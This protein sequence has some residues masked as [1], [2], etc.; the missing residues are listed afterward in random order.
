MSRKVFISFLGATNYGECEYLCE[1]KSY[2]R[3]RFIQ[4][5]TIRHLMSKE[6]WLPTDAAYI[7]MTVTSETNN[8][9]DFHFNNRDTGEPLT[10]LHS[11]LEKLSLP[12]P[13]HTI[14]ELPD[15]NNEQEIWQIFQ[16][17]FNECIQEG[18]ELYFDI[19][20]GYRYLPM[21]IVVLGN[22]AKFL[23]NITVKSITYGNYEISK[24][25]KKPG[26]IVDLLPL[27]ALQDWTYA[28]G[29]YIRSG[30]ASTLVKLGNDTVRPLMKMHKGQDK[31]TNNLYALVK[32]LDGLT[33]ELRTCRGSELIAAKTLK[34]LSEAC[35]EI[36]AATIPQLEPLISKIQESLTPFSLE[37][38]VKNGF[39][40]VDWCFNHGLYQ[41]AATLLE[42]SIITLLC[43]CA[44]LDLMN[45]TY[46]DLV[47]AA[48][49]CQ[50]HPE[51]PLKE[52]Y[53][54]Q[55]QIILNIQG[56][57][58]FE[59]LC[60]VYAPLSELRN[61]FNHAGMRVNHSK[62]DDIVIKLQ[63]YIATTKEI[64]QKSPSLC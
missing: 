22:Y 20:H 19:T 52:Q 45:R 56:T 34:R 6:E 1:G 43:K 21:L 53:K 40:A 26:L 7:L 15:G 32:S 38:D 59:E 54:E 49:Y 50:T 10:G 36:E 39:A 9:V 14:R 2:G 58:G 57:M 63:T 24:L 8:W 16:R 48:I 37:E 44:D 35:G 12:F 3:T 11:C 25:K 27:S 13:V 33:K 30:D 42:E 41:Q 61:D 31:N 17:V 28:S 5:T 55:Q 4:E 64:F 62:P 29:Q 18:D 51:E 60:S 23:R 47:S 46:R